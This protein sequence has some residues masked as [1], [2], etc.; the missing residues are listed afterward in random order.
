MTGRTAYLFEAPTQVQPSNKYVRKGDILYGED[1]GNGLVRTRFQNPD[2][3]V[4][5]GWVKRHALQPL[6][7][8]TPA[9]LMAPARRAS[10]LARRA[11]TTPSPASTE[12]SAPVPAVGARVH[13]LPGGLATAV[14]RVAKSYFFNSATLSQP[15]TRK[16]HCVRGD[17]VQLIQ[18]GG[19]AVYVRFTN[20][21]HVTTTGWMRK[22]ALDYH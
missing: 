22:D 17:Q 10:P 19:E 2:G 20:W 14:V 6:P 7:E 5:T 15:E 16:A 18:E 9:P 1:E 8:A 3:A 13:T 21:E 11:A 12:P 4:S